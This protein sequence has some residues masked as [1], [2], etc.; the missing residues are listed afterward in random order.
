MMAER[1]EEFPV[2]LIHL[3]W[4]LAA[5]CVVLAYQAFIGGAALSTTYADKHYVDRS[6]EVATLEA[7]AY[8]DHNHDD[9]LQKISS[10]RT[11]GIAQVS[12]L[13]S[14]IKVQSVLLG[15]VLDTLKEQRQ[16]A[17]REA[18]Q[19]GPTSRR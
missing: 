3:V 14:D 19:R 16:D 4:A 15:Q 5:G 10:L 8:S 18:V 11:E 12:Q 13:N 9:M 6:I 7:R 1:K 17:R 2:K